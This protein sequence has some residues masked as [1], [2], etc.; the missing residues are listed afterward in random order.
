MARKKYRRRRRS[1]SKGYQ[2][3]MKKN[4]K[5]PGTVRRECKVLPTRRNRRTGR[6][7]KG[8]QVCRVIAG[9]YRSKFTSAGAALRS[10][11]KL[12]TRLQKK[13]CAVG[14]GGVALGRYRRR[15]R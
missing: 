14:A 1:G 2:R 3:L 7:N 4:A 11:I 12:R 9:R 8:G 5:C 13:G 10:A 6:I 15:R